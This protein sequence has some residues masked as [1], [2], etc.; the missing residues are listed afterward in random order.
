MK[1]TKLDNISP[2][3]ITKNP[4]NPRLVFRQE[5]LDTLLNSIKKVG[6][7]VPLSIYEETEKKKYVLLDGERRWMCAKKLNLDKIP[8][9]IE[10]KPSRLENILRMF[11]IH[12]VRVQWDLYATAL[13]L[14]EVKRLLEKEG[15][16]DSIKDLAAVTGVSETTVK[17]AFEL[18]KLPKKYLHLL[19]E[20]L[21]RPKS[22][23]KFSEDFFLEMMKAVK[24]IE[25]YT[26]EIIEKTSKT[27]IM[28]SFKDKYE[29]GT[30]TNI[31]KFRNVSK[32]ARSENAGVPSS[33][34]VPIL[35]KLISDPK[36]TIDDAYQDSVAKAYEDRSLTRDIESISE[37]LSEINKKRLSPEFKALLKKMKNIIETLLE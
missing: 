31:V 24:V 22:E 25:R 2:D 18:L 36:Y 19:E 7:R 16:P 10:P 26:P 29:K 28:D 21:K 37:R 34:A 27:K 5:E 14:Q 15:K 6:I 13:K 4:D 17:R 9:I 33:K 32:I 23:Q 35:K 3:L 30:I 11:N 20:E 1:S 12:N 8:V